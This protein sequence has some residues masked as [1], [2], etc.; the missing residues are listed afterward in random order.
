M[1]FDK[2]SVDT[3]IN[4]QDDLGDCLPMNVNYEAAEEPVEIPVTKRI[5]FKIGKPKKQSIG[6]DDK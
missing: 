1:C 5:V 3:S 6:I 2:N 4:N